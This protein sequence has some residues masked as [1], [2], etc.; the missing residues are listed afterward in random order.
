MNENNNLS[1]YPNDDI[2]AVNKENNQLGNININSEIQINQME[3]SHTEQ[4]IPSKRT[5]KNIIANIFYIV[6]IILIAILV[7]VFGMMIFSSIIVYPCQGLGDGAKVENSLIKF[8]FEGVLVSAVYFSP[9]ILFVLLTF[10]W[11]KNNR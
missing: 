2:G 11:S 9:L 10:K 1:N 3:Q 4:S 6:D 8:V 5:I 7:F